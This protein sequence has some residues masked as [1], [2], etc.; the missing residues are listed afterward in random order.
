MKFGPSNCKKRSFHT[1]AREGN[2]QLDIQKEINL[3]NN[4]E[5]GIKN[6]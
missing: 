5:E 3:T 2:A 4:K 6:L 1:T